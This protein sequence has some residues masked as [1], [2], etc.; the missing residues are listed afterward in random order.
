MGVPRYRLGLLSVADAGPWPVYRLAVEPCGVHLG[1]RGDV[2]VRRWSGTLT[3]PCVSDR[4]AD[5]LLG[6]GLGSLC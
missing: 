5:H 4:I 2:P 1:H 6:L 3:A